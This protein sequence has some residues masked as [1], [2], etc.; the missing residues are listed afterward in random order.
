MTAV[1]NGNSVPARNTSDSTFRTLGSTRFIR[2]PICHGF[3]RNYH[4][5]LKTEPENLTFAVKMKQ[6]WLSL[7][8]TLQL[9]TIPAIRVYT[10][11]A[12]NPAPDPESKITKR[13]WSNE[14]SHPGLYKVKLTQRGYIQFLR[15]LVDVPS[16]QQYTFCLWVMSTNYTYN[17]PIFSYSR[18]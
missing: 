1:P 5:I 2:N 4:D 6:A 3:H 10:G 12:V 9:S 13:S 17:H 11:T 16:L 18:K 14:N 8:L 15:Y 7:L